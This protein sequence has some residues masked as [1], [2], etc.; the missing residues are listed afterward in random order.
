MKNSNTEIFNEAAASYDATFTLSN[1][2]KLQ[3]ERVYFFLNQTNLFKNRRKVFELNCGTGFDA[4][5]FYKKGLQVIATDGSSKM[6][7][8]C[9]KSRSREIDFY[10]LG[11]QEI[12]SDNKIEQTDFLF[13]N[14]G[15]LNCLSTSELDNFIENISRK[16]K[17]NDQI[18]W[19]IMPKNCF[20]ESV[21]LFF[22][23]KW[24]QIGRRNTNEAV[25]VEVEGE[26][27]PTY[28][29]SPKEIR[30]KLQKDYEIKF[31][32]PIAFF[33]PPSYLEPFFKKRKWL[34]HIL[35]NFEKL[36]AN[37]SFLANWSDH[38]IIV[39]ERK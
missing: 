31:A 27:V 9:K 38:F 2:G 7:E 16:Q 5:T 1:I 24:S 28:Y 17:S 19:V 22:K 32:K 14:F 23:G 6:I 26:Q 3:R 37:H 10:R 33:L 21:Y 8:I 12:G 11:F 36:F 13:S 25:M 18:T 4:E 29:Y 34:L 20:W 39:A 35:N 30:K 15:G